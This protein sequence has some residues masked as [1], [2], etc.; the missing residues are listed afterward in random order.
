LRDDARAERDQDK[1][2]QELRVEFPLKRALF[3]MLV[4]GGWCCSR[5][6]SICHVPFFI[7]HR[8]NCDSQ[9]MT[10]EKWNMAN[11]K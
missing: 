1:S 3:H 5:A 4:V 11:G 6:F 7:C 2:A 10:N 8:R 9:V